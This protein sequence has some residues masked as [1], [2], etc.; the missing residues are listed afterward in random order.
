MTITYPLAFPTTSGISNIQ[1][2]LREA[3]SSSVSPYDFSEQVYQYQG[4]V[5]EASVSIPPMLRADA[6]YFDAF[7][8]K[9]RGKYGT[10]LLGDPAGKTPR[11]TWAGTPLVNGGSQTGESLVCDGFT[12]GATV[13]A[14]DYFQLG[15]GSASR[16]YKIVTDG[17]ADGSGNLTLEFEPRII[18]APADNAALT[19]SNAVGVFRLVDNFNP[20]N[21]DNFS[22]F[23][24]SFKARA[25]I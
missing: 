13:K 20:T 1:I 4:Q 14:G 3:V 22:H 6:A 16:L 24:Y 10:F 25:V 12:A 19:S 23:T 9:L 15:S 11:G 21:I 8:L 5:W 18:S 17:T 2:G 7:F